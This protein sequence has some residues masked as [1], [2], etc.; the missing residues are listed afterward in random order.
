MGVGGGTPAVLKAFCAGEEVGKALSLGSC[1]LIT[2]NQGDRRVLQRVLP[3]LCRDKATYTPAYKVLLTRHHLFSNTE[4]AGRG[5]GLAAG[6]AQAWRL[7]ML[8]GGR[9]QMA[10]PLCLATEGE[11]LGTRKHP[12]AARI[13]HFFLSICEQE[14]EG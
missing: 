4:T 11:Y 6:A 3:I 1:L 5:R 12:S 9:S 14:D 7:H 10:L 8:E 13:H 2:M